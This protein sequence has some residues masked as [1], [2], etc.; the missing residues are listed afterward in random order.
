MNP[1]VASRHNTVQN[2]AV[3]E[4]GVRQEAVKQEAGIWGSVRKL[5]GNNFIHLITQTWAERIYRWATNR[6]TDKLPDKSFGYRIGFADMHRMYMRYLHAKLTVIAIS[7]HS[8][9]DKQKW[10]TVVG[11]LGPTLE[12]YG[13]ITPTRYGVIV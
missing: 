7:L 5:H 3:I 10:Q 8:E 9:K 13:T 4:D 11:S 1:T 12:K 2:D 6:P